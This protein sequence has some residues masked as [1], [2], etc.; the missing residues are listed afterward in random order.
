V[1]EVTAGLIG[2]GD[3]VDCHLNALKANPEYKLTGICRRSP[4]KLKAQAAKLGVKG[5]VDYRDM[6]AD[7]PDV[8][9]VSLPHN[10]HY[11]VALEALA[12]GCHVLM[13][14]PVA[15]GMQ[16]VNGMIAAAGKAGRMILP[17][18]SSY[19]Q[20]PFR[21]AR[22]IVHRGELG[23][24]LFGNFANHRFYFTASRPSWFLKP[25]TSGGGQ[26][27]NIGVHRMSGVRCILGDD[28]EE[29]SVTASV[30]RIHPEH[31]IE[32]ATR[33]MVVY[34]DGEAMTY[35]ECGYLK[36]PPELGLG[37]HFVF[38]HG[39]LGIAAGKLWSSDRDGNVTQHKLL[40]ETDGGAYGALYGQMLKAIE[41]RDHY[42]TIRHG[43][44]DARIALAAYASADQGQTIDLRDSEWIIRNAPE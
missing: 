18:E 37:L 25:D 1:P 43:A 26:F 35:E 30:H 7:K 10:L 39:L 20:P 5:Y 40:P 15:V 11:Q 29:A 36:P 21:T 13:E 23:K 27:M 33:A 8:V 42:P 28:Y 14:K 34:A 3:I 44:M 19:W 32:A 4:E 2:I 24:L 12:A 41:G 17:T 6:L 16:E 31:D 38:E 22:E 9:L